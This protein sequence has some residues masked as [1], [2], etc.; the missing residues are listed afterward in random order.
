MYLGEIVRRVLL[1]MAKE[2]AL[3][4]DS[5]PPNLAIPFK[6]RTPDISAMHSDTSPDLKVA[7]RKLK[8]VLEIPYS[9]VSTRK[10]VV[11]LCR[12][13]AER[14]ARLAGAGVVG[15]L[16]KIGRDHVNKAAEDRCCNGWGA[17]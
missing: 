12:I 9:S 2:A 17:L 10:I 8:D 16:R 4:G 13:I 3:F 11:E 14:G 6:L 1:R 7:G 5:I 15:I